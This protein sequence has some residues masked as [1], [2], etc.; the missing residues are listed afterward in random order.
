[1]AQQNVYF[2]RC[3][4]YVKERFFSKMNHLKFIGC[5]KDYIDL[6]VKLE[7]VISENDFI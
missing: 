6:K 7:N 2:I 4:R 1:M 5:Q 3:I